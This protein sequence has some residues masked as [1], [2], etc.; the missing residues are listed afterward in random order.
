MS[1]KHNNPEPL[2]ESVAEFRIIDKYIYY[3]SAADKNLYRISVD[4]SA[5]EK[6]YDEP[7]DKLNTDGKKLIFETAEGEKL[8]NIKSLRVMEQ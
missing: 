5:E 4:G 7:C 6:L 1:T 3:V 2:K 8:M